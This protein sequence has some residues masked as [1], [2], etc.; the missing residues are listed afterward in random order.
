[1]RL[2]LLL[3]MEKSEP[4]TP[5]YNGLVPPSQK[6]AVPT[7]AATHQAQA[8]G[9][10]LGTLWGSQRHLMTQPDHS[11]VAP[12]WLCQGVPW[13]HLPR[14]PPAMTITSPTNHYKGL[15]TTARVFDV[16]G[17][18][19]VSEPHIKCL[20][21]HFCLCGFVREISELSV[22]MLTPCHP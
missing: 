7:H 13:E 4:L 15:I 1:M 3:Q 17:S 12:R 16:G 18:L 10:G 19:T 5:T 14:P 20:Q 21:N 22:S 11:D 6:A 2:N 8:H 9:G